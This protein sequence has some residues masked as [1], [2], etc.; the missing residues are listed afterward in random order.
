MQEYEADRIGIII[1]AKAGYDPHAA[2]KFWE[3]FIGSDEKSE[4]PIFF[5]T[6]PTDRDRLA[7]I[8]ECIPEAMNYFHHVPE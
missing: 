6:H 7:K 5:S 8:R 4:L 2:I 3:Q 1:M